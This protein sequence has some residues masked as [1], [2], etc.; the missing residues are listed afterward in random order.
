VSIYDLGDLYGLVYAGALRGDIG[1]G[2]SGYYF[3]VSGE[4][5]WLA[6]A[7]TIGATMVK[8]GWAKE[9]QPTTFTDEEM[10]KYYNNSTYPGTNSRAVADR[11]KSIGW[12]PKQTELE[13]FVEYLRSETLR[14][15][16]TF[17]KTRGEVKSTAYTN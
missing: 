15:E 7:Q 12:K 11:S 13:D 9:A 3:G 8:Q 2:K 4:Y 5:T 14:V 16:K 6:A 17:G 1:H 10:K